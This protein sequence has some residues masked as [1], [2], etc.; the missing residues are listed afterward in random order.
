MKPC[1]EVEAALIELVFGEPATDAEMILHRHLAE[2]AACRDQ[3]RRLLALRDAIRDEG[4][5]P[6]AELRARVRAAVP[7]RPPSGPLGVLTRPIPAYA[8]AA[9]CLLGVLAAWLLLPGRRPGPAPIEKA[10]RVTDAALATRALPFM[11]AG[12][13]DTG[14]R[15]ARPVASLRDSSVP[16]RERPNNL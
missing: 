8:A 9:A 1:D 14:V 3:E 2:C 10:P 5:E 7:R 13:Y 11:P 16:G 12:S 15:A 4:A 6:S